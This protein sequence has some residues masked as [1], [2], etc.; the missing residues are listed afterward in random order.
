MKVR[1]KPKEFFTK[2]PAYD[3]FNEALSIGSGFVDE[4]FKDCG[5]VI[6]FK[7]GNLQH[8]GHDVYYKEEEFDIYYKLAWNTWMWDKIKDIDSNGNFLLDFN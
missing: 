4:M 6:S 2:N 3:S 8:G 7:K 5:K 1:I